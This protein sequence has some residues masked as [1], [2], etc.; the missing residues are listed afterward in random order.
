M[1]KMIVITLVCLSFIT[2]GQILVIDAGEGWKPK[3][4]SALTV[5]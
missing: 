4:D 1:K 3:V 5:I 2:K